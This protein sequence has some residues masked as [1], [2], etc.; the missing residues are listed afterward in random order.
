MRNKAVRGCC[1]MKGIVSRYFCLCFF[2]LSEQ[3]LLEMSYRA[4]SSVIDL[5]YLNLKRTPQCLQHRGVMTPQC[6][7]HWGVTICQ[8]LENS[9]VLTAL[10]RQIYLVMQAVVKAG[11][12]G[13]SILLIVG[14]AGESHFVT[15]KKLH[16][17]F[18]TR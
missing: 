9:T 12:T 18:D 14:S 10:L 17:T 16:N 11:N 13:E 3:L 6:W 1:C 5:F 2:I 15:L 8:V 4:I 7:K